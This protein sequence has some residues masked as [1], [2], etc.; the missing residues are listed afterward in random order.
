[1]VRNSDMQV[2]THT[3]HFSLASTFPADLCSL[4]AVVMRGHAVWHSIGE[5]GS[6]TSGM[7]SE[8]AAG[9][10]VGLLVFLSFV[11]IIHHF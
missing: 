5:L 1:V 4:T 8:E 10:F 7:N 9:R 11:H 3:V 6:A 2:N